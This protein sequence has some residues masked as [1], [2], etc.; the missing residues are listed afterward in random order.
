MPCCRLKDVHPI[1][2]GLWGRTANITA[3]ASH[4]NWGKVSGCAFL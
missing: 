3:K 1:N 4:G 2:A